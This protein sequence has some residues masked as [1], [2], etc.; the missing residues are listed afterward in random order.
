[1]RSRP[2]EL[3][4]EG[5]ASAGTIPWENIAAVDVHSFGMQRM[6]VIAV[7]DTREVVDRASGLRRLVLTTNARRMATPVNIPA[8][9]LPMRARDVESEITT[10]LTA[11]RE[12]QIRR[13]DDHRGA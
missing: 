13:Q 9:M 1:M 8:T 11:R 10:H 4:S 3:S 7:R 5:T 6:L 2:R 12:E